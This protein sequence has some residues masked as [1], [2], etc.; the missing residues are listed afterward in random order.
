MDEEHWSEIKVRAGGNK[1]RETGEWKDD[2]TINLEEVDGLW[3]DEMGNHLGDR[4][5]G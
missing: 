4:G 5:R 3:K 2:M 1:K